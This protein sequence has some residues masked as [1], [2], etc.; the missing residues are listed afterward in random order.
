MLLKFI[1]DSM[2]WNLWTIFSFFKELY[3]DSDLID[4]FFIGVLLKSS[5]SPIIEFLLDPALDYSLVSA[6]SVILSRGVI[7]T[8][9]SSPDC[10]LSCS[11]WNTIRRLLAG[12]IKMFLTFPCTPSHVPHPMCPHL[13]ATLDP[14]LLNLY[15]LFFPFHPFDWELHFFS[16]QNQCPSVIRTIC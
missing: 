11:I 12:F 4:W 13:S 6:A 8:F 5:F 7:V 2:F 1:L 15:L 9:C 16:L 10:N 14:L 3:F